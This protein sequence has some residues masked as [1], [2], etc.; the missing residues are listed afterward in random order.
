MIKILSPDFTYSDGR[1]KLTQLIHDGFKQVN[2]IESSPGSERG[3]HYHELNKEAFFIAEGELLLTVKKGSDSQRYTFNKGDMFLIPS[4]TLH[5]FIFPS[6]TILISM[7]DNGVEIG[8]GNK[9]IYN[10]SKICDMLDGL[11]EA[12]CTS[13]DAEFTA[14]KQHTAYCLEV[15][16]GTDSPQYLQFISYSFE[17]ECIRV[18]D[19]YRQILKNYCR[20][21]LKCI[22]DIF[23]EYNRN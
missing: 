14:W 23:T 2:V 21:K 12:E 19:N 3:G 20:E 13:L 6:K 1:G 4:M 11:I 16:F 22:R 8:D 7:Y 5:D 17:P 9:D 18:S 10:L 15:M